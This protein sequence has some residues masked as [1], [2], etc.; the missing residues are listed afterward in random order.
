[1]IGTLIAATDASPTC[2]E[3]TKNIVITSMMTIRTT[4]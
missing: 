2:M 3:N 4:E 1:M